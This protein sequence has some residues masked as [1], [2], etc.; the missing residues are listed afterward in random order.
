LQVPLLGIYPTAESLAAQGIM[1][2]A[3]IMT[4]MWM[5]REQK[6]A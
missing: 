1:L 5:A 2:C 6:K 4:S 3:F